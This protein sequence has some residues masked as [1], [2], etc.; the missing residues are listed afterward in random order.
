MPL[1]FQVQRNKLAAQAPQKWLDNLAPK[2]A[3][4]REE[5]ARRDLRT[6]AER[7]GAAFD[8][9]QQT[10]QIELWGKPYTLVHP[11]LVAR[12]ATGAEAS[13]YKQ[14]LF[15]MYLDTADETPPAHKWLAYRELPGGM[16]YANAFHGY[17]ELRLAQ[18]FNGDLAR[19]RTAAVGLKGSRLTFGDASFEFVALPRILVAAVYWLGDEDFPSNASILFDAAAS[20][21][22]PTD[23]VGALGSQLVSRLIGQS[24][25]DPQTLTALAIQ[26]PDAA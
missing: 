7:S 26:P 1:R 21:Y 19:F 15:L 2:V 11:E 12:D 10:I 6:L 18:A 13:T 16:F 9:A 5:L 20:H 24:D 23:A 4:L 3:R 14:A 17:A 22:L 25:E 8:A